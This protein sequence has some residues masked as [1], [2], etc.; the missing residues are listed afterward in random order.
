MGAK[1][2]AS[3]T[4]LAMDDADALSRCRF[5]IL[6]SPLA[7]P[8]LFPSSFISPTS[9]RQ[10]Q[11]PNQLRSSSASWSTKPSSSSAVAR[12]LAEARRSVL[13]SSSRKFD[14][15]RSSSGTSISK[16]LRLARRS[17]AKSRTDD[18]TSLF[19]QE[20][21]AT[22]SSSLSTSNPW[23][24]PLAASLL[25]PSGTCRSA[26]ELPTSSAR[27]VVSTLLRGA[28]TDAFLA[29]HTLDHDTPCWER[30]LLRTQGAAPVNGRRRGRHPPVRGLA[31]LP[32][33]DPFCSQRRTSHLLFPAVA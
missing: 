20:P 14:A 6:S 17:A 9:S 2:G 21:R 4:S 7:T 10:L 26:C 31:R 22:I 15:R 16:R 29:V 33:P 5:A 8:Q 32:S 25:S 11:R 24:S 13:T 27:C 12:P 1:R 30:M 23:V 28:G 3:A 19:C 18:G